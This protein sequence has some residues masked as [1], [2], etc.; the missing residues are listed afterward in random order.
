MCFIWR[1]MV[2]KNSTNQYSSKIGQKTGTGKKVRRKPNRNA[3]ADEYLRI[4]HDSQ[5]CCFR[6]RRKGARAL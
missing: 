3:F 6:G 1:F 5:S 2:M 4:Q